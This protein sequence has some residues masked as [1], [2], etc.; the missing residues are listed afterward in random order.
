MAHHPEE[1]YF[2]FEQVGTAAEYIT[3]VYAEILKHPFTYF[4]IL[5]IQAAKR[6]KNITE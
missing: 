5:V 1:H 6:H 4:S 3:S 2:Y